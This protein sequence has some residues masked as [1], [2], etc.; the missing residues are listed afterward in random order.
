MRRKDREKPYD[1]AYNVLK[2]TEYA[3]LSMTDP[4]GAPY[5]IP[6]SPVVDGDV[7]YFHC[8]AEGKKADCIRRD[9]RVCIACA[10]NTH[11]LQE[12]FTTEYESAVAFGNA[13]FIE[14][15]TEKTEALVKL[16][17]KYSPSVPVQKVLA[18]IEK[19]LHRTAVCRVELTEITGK[20]K[21]KK[22]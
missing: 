3:F 10:G 2:N 21:E 18:A 16:C 7:L 14:N 20:A 5:C 22:Q 19:S 13:R 9:G 1:W 15:D 12:E 4:S 8:A 11:V 17:E 6:I